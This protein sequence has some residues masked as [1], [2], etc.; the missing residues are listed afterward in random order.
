MTGDMGD[1]WNEIKTDRDKKKK[2]LGIDCPG[3]KLL[4]PKTYP[5]RLI[6]GKKCKAC[7]MTY[8]QAKREIKT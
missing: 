6:P 1:Y 7:G 3:C 2:E 5:T 8:S 4:R